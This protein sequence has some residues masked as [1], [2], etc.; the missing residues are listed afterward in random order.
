MKTVHRQFGIFG[1]TAKPEIA[2][3]THQLVS[4]LRKKKISFFVHDELAKWVNS[5]YSARFV[6]KADMSDKNFLPQKCEVII[7][8]GGDGTM[9]QAARLTGRY[10]KPI[11]GVNVGKLGFLAEISTKDM[12]H[13]ILDMLKGDYRVEERMVL[14]AQNLSD[15]KHFYGLN[16]IVIDKGTT[17][18]V[19]SIETHV[20]D[21][22]LTTYTAD[23]II[24]NTP[25]GSTGYSLST[26]GP[27]V[28][29]PTQVITINPIAPHTLTARPVIVP[30]S[31]VIRVIV[32]TDAR[33]V[34]LTSDGQEDRLYTTPTEF[35]IKK[36]PYTVKLVKR[37]KGS[38]YDTLRKKLLWGRDPRVRG[39]HKYSILFEKR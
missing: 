31:S 35:I 13:C 19:I 37:T 24:L 26:G 18:R 10:G 22:Y 5:I 30:D 1:N 15:K 11:L 21:D 29:P 14:E 7:V 39:D 33:H 20:D 6:S 3:V 38:F 34:R 23:G 16:D 2:R 28:V 12:D 25:T 27:I 4:F 9:L 36:A 8:L 17:S 32:H